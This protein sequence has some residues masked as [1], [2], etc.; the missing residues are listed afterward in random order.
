MAL[1]LELQVNRVDGATM[2]GKAIVEETDVMMLTGAGGWW[3]YC[4]VLWLVWHVTCG[5]WP[6]M[7][8]R[9]RALKKW[10]T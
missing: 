1:Q 6:A 5:V 8:V 7:A 9:W 2:V 4:D 10:W 3:C